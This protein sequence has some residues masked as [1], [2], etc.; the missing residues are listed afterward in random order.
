MTHVTLPGS[1]PNHPSLQNKFYYQS[2][3]LSYVQRLHNEKIGY[4]DCFY[5]N[6][7]RYHWSYFLL[8]WKFHKNSYSDLITYLYLIPMKLS[9]LFNI[10]IGVRWWR[11]S[12]ATLIM[13]EAGCSK[14]TTS[15]STQ[16]IR[17][18]HFSTTSW[19]ILKQESR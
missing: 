10:L 4:N 14:D 16:Q 1:Q 18:H 15:Y 6:M 19:N 17:N 13:L 2:G 11:I 12:Q 3:G 9:C 7:Y 8:F 5:K